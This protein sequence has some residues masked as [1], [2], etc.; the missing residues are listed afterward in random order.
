MASDTKPLTSF[1][2]FLGNWSAKKP[3]TYLPVDGENWGRIHPKAHQRL[4]SLITRKAVDFPTLFILSIES[5]DSLI[6]DALISTF[7]ADALGQIETDHWRF[8]KTLTR[9]ICRGHIEIIKRLSD[10]GITFD[11]SR[12]DLLFQAVAL[13]RPDYIDLLFDL[14]PGR[15]LLDVAFLFFAL[16]N[17]G[18]PSIAKPFHKMLCQDFISLD[19]AYSGPRDPSDPP[20]TAGARAHI[21]RT[22]ALLIRISAEFGCTRIISSPRF[23]VDAENNTLDP[24]LINLRDRCLSAHGRL[25]LIDAEPDLEAMLARPRGEAFFGHLPCWTGTTGSTAQKA[26]STHV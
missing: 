21:L 18:G 5:G 16:Y 19:G 23:A 25:W 1:N 7:G 20:Q 6:F 24:N 12:R 22:A 2:A 17:P 11:N 4:L 13:K 26:K 10:L 15:T 8:E 14:F 9:A 3:D